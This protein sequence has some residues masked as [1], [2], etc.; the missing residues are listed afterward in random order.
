[1][2]VRFALLISLCFFAPLHLSRAADFQV[3]ASLDRNQMA[4]NEQAVLSLVVAGG[5]GDLP[6]PQ[7]PNL[8]EFQISNAGRAQ[9]FSWVNGKASASITYSYVLTPLKEGRFTIPPIR[10]QYQNQTAETQAMTLDVV[11]ADSVAAPA[12]AQE[13]GARRPVASQGPAAVFITGS[14]DKTTV[15]VGEPVTYVFRLYN[16]VPLLSRPNYQ[17]PETTGFWTEDLPP[18]RNFTAQVKGVPYNVTEVRTALFPSSPGKAKV[19]S[20]SLAVQMENFGTDPFGSDFFASFF[21]RG[22]QRVLKTEPVN[23]HV[24][25]LPEP[26][27]AGFKGA[28]GRF[29]LT[30]QT[31]KDTV[32][33]GQPLTLT[34]TVA[35]KGNIKSLPELTLPPFT[36]F[37]TF[38]ANA[39]TNIDKKDGEVEGSKV[40]KTVLIPTA[41]GDIK[42]PPI[43]FVFFDTEAKAYKTVHS[44]PINVRVTPGA[45]SS[46]GGLPAPVPTASSVDTPGIRLLGEDIRYIKTPGSISSQGDPLYQRAW[47]RWL[48]GFLLLLLSAGVLFR[49]YHRLF[50]SNTGLYRFRKAREKALAVGRSA[51]T[52]LLKSD[53]K[54]AA[55]LLANGLQ[56]YVAA[57][58]VVESR[59]VALKDIL[60]RLRM[61]GMHPHTAE[62]IRN[63]WETLDL[64]QFAPAQVRVE[65]VR[66]SLRTFEHVVDEID[67]EIL[68]K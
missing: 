20:A 66:Q 19:G 53:I 24:K 46:S 59:T 36:N 10:F 35:G 63:L 58:L 11:K 45:A 65:E 52:R 41:S 15:Y 49:I 7:L 29:T 56:D 33:V 50:L 64:F 32:G 30:G 23:V 44:R 8:S 3:S 16:R 5:G 21:N 22:E 57:K 62:K 25:A 61:K 17:P 27:P 13:E 4:L 9:N 28:V 48:H 6:Q 12:T 43:D 60:E 47:F 42:I 34:L 38:D 40:F 37:R 68:W 51:D 18:Q 31:D 55:G 1:M 39:A 26:K 54:G 67:R 2:P 14:V